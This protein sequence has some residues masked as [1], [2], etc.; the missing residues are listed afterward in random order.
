MSC[1]TLTGE[2]CIVI[3]KNTGNLKFVFDEKWTTAYTNWCQ[4]FY[5]SAK[6]C[7]IMFLSI[8]LV[9]FLLF[10]FTLKNPNT[11]ISL[12][13]NSYSTSM[14]RLIATCNS[15]LLYVWKI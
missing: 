11:V 4:C 14:D 10:L 3:F 7:V 8:G 5:T 1:V 9:C 15:H 6:I 13:S 12:L 2:D